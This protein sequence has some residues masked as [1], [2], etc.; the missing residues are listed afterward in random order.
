MKFKFSAGIIAVFSAFSLM[1]SACGDDSGS[2]AND[3]LPESVEL[4][5]DMKNIECNADRECAQ[6]YIE[7]HDDYVQCIDSKWKTVI[8][9]KP[10][11]ACAEAKSSSSKG[12][13]S[14][15]EKSNQAVV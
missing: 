6:V 8:A 1:F 3:E 14:S 10:N 11:E 4:F 7:E 2:S 5:V 13:S 12:K 9:S 15:S